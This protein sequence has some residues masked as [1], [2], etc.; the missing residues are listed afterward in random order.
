MT[1]KVKYQVRAETRNEFG[2]LEYEVIFESNSLETAKKEYDDLI[3]LYDESNLITLAMYWVK[4]DCSAVLE[5]KVNP[6]GDNYKKLRK[7]E[8]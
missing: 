5:S 2:D 4:D 8:R 3:G 1:E 7:E 6:Y